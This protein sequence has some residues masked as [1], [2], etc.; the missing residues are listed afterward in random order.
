[1]RPLDLNMRTCFLKIK[2]TKRE[3]RNEKKANVEF[4]MN[5]DLNFTDAQIQYYQYNISVL[6]IFLDGF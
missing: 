2:V 1:M 6:I 4:I 5:I 3:K